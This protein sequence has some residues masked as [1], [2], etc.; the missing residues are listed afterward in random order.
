[1]DETLDFTF[2]DFEIPEKFNM[3]PGMIIKKG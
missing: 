1:M 2:E 3:L